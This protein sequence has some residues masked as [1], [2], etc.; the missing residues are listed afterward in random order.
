MGMAIVLLA[1]VFLAGPSVVLCKTLLQNIGTYLSS[2]VNTT[3]NMYAYE[4]QEEWFGGWTLFYWAWWIAWSPFVGVFVAKIS[5]GRTIREF[6]S[7]ALF[8]PVGFTVLWFTVFG[9]SALDSIINDAA[10]DLSQVVSTSISQALFVFFEGLPFSRFI[11]IYTLL[12]LI[13]FFVS[14]VDSGA[15]VIN[16]LTSVVTQ[17]RKSRWRGVL[18]ACLGCL[19]ACALLATGGLGALQLWLILTAY[20]F[21]LIMLV[22][23]VAL[24]KQLREDSMLSDCVQTH[25]T[26]IQYARTN[27]SWEQRLESLLHH[28]TAK[29]ARQF[30]KTVAQPALEKLSQQMQQQGLS[31]KLTMEVNKVMLTINKDDL[32]DFSYGVHLRR[33]AVP[34]YADEE[35]DGYYRAEVFLSQGGQRYDVLGY[36]EQQIIA[37]ALTQYER[38]LHFLH[39]AASET[40]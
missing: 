10:S 1:F 12:L 16:E 14:S 26:S 8:V 22:Y 33:Y 18:W 31:T 25:H 4:P 11:S 29:E 37:D 3:F 21:M 15:L 5:R 30:L 27:V 2:L 28:P 35:N 20:P 36:T 24:W 34:S 9:N 39:L 17:D 19:I 38:H 6:I 40:L 23:C 13:I 32:E 7:G